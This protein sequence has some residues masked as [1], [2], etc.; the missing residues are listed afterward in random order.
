MKKTVASLALLILFCLVPA[1]LFAEGD[2]VPRITVQEL[3][4]MMDSKAPVVI[5]DAQPKRAYDKGHIKGAISFPW[6]PK[7]SDEQIA[8]IPKGKPIVV[9]CDCGPGEADSVSVAERLLERG[10][11]DVKVLK[12]PSIRG[13]KEAGFPTE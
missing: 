10:F 6:A 7:L 3:K 11:N 1:C 2:D 9:Y 4:K 12:D 5:L 8:A 13:W